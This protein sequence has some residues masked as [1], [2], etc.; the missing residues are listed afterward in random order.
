VLT[1]WISIYVLDLYLPCQNGSCFRLLEFI[2]QIICVRF[3]A[4]V[5][6]KP[7]SDLRELPA[8]VM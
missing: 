5:V 7:S 3:Q 8:S 1:S 6:M 4:V 2:T